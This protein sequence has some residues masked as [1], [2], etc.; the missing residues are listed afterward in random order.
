MY[1]NYEDENE[2]NEY[3][4][5]YL[6]I[7]TEQVYNPIKE[8]PKPE[9]Y[10]P[11]DEDLEHQYYEYIKEMIDEE[12]SKKR[13]DNFIVGGAM[14]A[15]GAASFLIKRYFDKKFVD[16]YNEKFKNETD[17]GDKINKEKTMKTNEYEKLKINKN[18]HK[19]MVNDQNEALKEYN[20]KKEIISNTIK[21]K[22]DDRRKK[23]IQNNHE[24]FQQ[25]V[26]YNE[27]SDNKI[28]DEE[29]NKLG[30][31]PIDIVKRIIYNYNSTQPYKR[32]E[33]L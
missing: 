2:K 29:Y 26:K 30:W 3:L 21:E 11:N 9:Y 31:G 33:D 27:F 17:I 14:M 5:N 12:Q 19:K 24:N 6:S 13:R 8:I 18:I 4:R 20:D 25:D 7:N 16:E 22:L 23:I 28:N 10:L 15:A 1:D 32:K